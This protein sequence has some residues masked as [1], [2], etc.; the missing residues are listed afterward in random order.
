MLWIIYIFKCS[1]DSLYTGITNNLTKRLQLLSSG[2]GN[3]YTK[4]E[5]FSLLDKKFKCLVLTIFLLV[6]PSIKSGLVEELINE[7]STLQW[8]SLKLVTPSSPNKQELA[9]VECIS[10][11]LI[12]VLDEPLQKIDWEIV[13]LESE[14]VNA[15]ALPGGKI[16]VFTGLLN[17]ASDQDEIA[18]VISHE[19]MH[20]IH[21]HSYERIKKQI[22]ANLI[23]DIF[24]LESSDAE[25]LNNLII[26]LP[27]SRKQEVQADLRGLSLMAKA[28]FN[29]LKSWFFWERM[30]N[31][32]TSPKF[33]EFIQTHPH[34]SSRVELIKQSLP[35][36]LREYNKPLNESS[37]NF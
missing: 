26:Q 1:D 23:M 30:G 11:R 10:K 13:I 37:C 7:F 28:G 31:Q 18:A 3:K 14:D 20:V 4:G 34:P 25:M 16:G 6:S 27:F 12:A 19:I 24:D 17:L 33:L 8:E 2:N 36:K 9:S 35:E 22:E 32:E 21:K 15:F 29:P 5:S